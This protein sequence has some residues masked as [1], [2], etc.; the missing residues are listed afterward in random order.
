MTT[1]ATDQDYLEIIVEALTGDWAVARSNE[2]PGCSWSL[3][4]GQTDIAWFDPASREAAPNL[5]EWAH[6]DGIT[7]RAPDGLVPSELSP[8]DA[9]Y[10]ARRLAEEALKLLDEELCNDPAADP[11]SKP[12]GGSPGPPLHDGADQTPQGETTMTA[13]TPPDGC[14][15]CGSIPLFAGQQLGPHDCQ[16]PQPPPGAPERAAEEIGRT[17]AGW[18]R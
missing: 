14:P 13:Y 10:V 17:I 15:D 8:E 18:L 2:M 5:A 7:A 1:A 12:G 11:M 4:H 16:P 6:A 3:S 9:H